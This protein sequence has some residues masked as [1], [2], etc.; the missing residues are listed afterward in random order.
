MPRYRPVDPKVS[1][2]ELDAHVLAF[3]KERHVFRASLERRRGA[4]EWVFYDGPPTANNRPHIGHVEARTFKDLYPRYRTMT[5]HYVHRKAGWD[6][7]GLPVEVEVERRIGT[8]SKRD[9]EEFGVARFVELCRTSVKEYVDDWK[10]MSDRLGHWIDMEDDYW[11]MDPSYVQSVWWALKQ[12]FDR[13]LLFQDHRSAAYCPRCGT[14][15]SDAEVALGYTTVVD[16]SVYVRFPVAEGPEAVRGA[17]LLGWTTTPWTLPSNL[18]LAVAADASYVRVRAG[19]EEVVLAEPLVGVVLPDGQ[20]EVL[21]RLS[22]AEMVGTR[23]APPYDN[24]DSGTHRVVAADFVSM[25]DGTGIVH[26]APGFGEDDLQLGRREGWPVYKPVDDAGHFTD[27][28]PAFVRGRFVKDTDPDIIED[29]RARGLL[30]RHED[31]EHTYP[32]CWRCSTPLLYL[33]RTSWYVR[34]TARKDGLLAANEETGW[35]PDYIKHGRYGNWLANNVDWALSRERYWGTPLPLWVCP[36]GHV[37]AVGS[38][39]ELTALAG[40]DVTGIDP[41][42]PAIDEVAIACPECAAEARRVPEVIDAWFD[43]GAMPYAQWGYMGPDSP[44]AEILSRRYPADFIAEGLDQTR[45]WFYSL[46]AEG[47]LLF[48]RSSY[49][50]VICH[51][52]VVDR[53]GRKM[54]KRL[55]NVIDPIEALDRYGADALRWLFVAGG[56]PWANRRLSLDAIGEVVRQFLLTLWNVYAFYV[57]YANVDEPD[58]AAAAP[59]AERPPL[60]RWILSRLHHLI[61]DVR[62]GMDEFDATGA[63]RRI[64]EF[65]N[66]L[67]NWYVRRSRRRFWDPV[68]AGAGTAATDKLAAHATLEECLRTLSLLL[69][70]FTPFVAEELYGNLVAERDPSAPESVHLCDFPQ[71]DPAIFDD[72]LEQEMEE[73]RLAVS[74]G[75]TVRTEQKVRVRQPLPAALLHGPVDPERLAPLLPLMAE[76][77]NVK[78]VRFAASADELGGWRARPNFRVMGPRLGTRAPEAAA[79]LA[80]DDGTL[81]AE[82]AHGR[83]VTV[84][85]PSG[86]AEVG[87]EDVSLA[88]HI[89]AGW[90]LASGGAVTVALDLELTDELRREGLAREL[91]HHVQGLRKASGLEVADR[92]VLGIEAGGEPAAAAAAY[93]DEIAAEVLATDVRAAAVEM[94]AGSVDV[95]LEGTPVRLT[96]RRA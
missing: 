19:G 64:E 93:R 21:A 58:L 13:G 72:A 32:L 41:H 36:G 78:E 63:A 14:G 59:L 53:D 1:F 83:P 33:A 15:L 24:V 90:A 81:A 48:G 76:E 87:P 68:R 86:A 94:A 38:L 51:G 12:L 60:D 27:E 79:A 3:W 11:T 40:R 34:T 55:G 42:R 37:T 70:P 82:L 10:I 20:P 16:P 73:V 28:A 18:G 52:L 2:P 77:L 49:R 67:S 69:A 95:D 92:I 6:C 8:K 39:A 75:R 29:L 9:I 26:V 46:M 80:A 61:D 43:S 50:N 74:L 31:Y 47:V 89:R 4:P 35:H 88:Q 56:S 22:G 17:A 44:A 57:T 85:L 62:A 91:I 30:L 84:A 54:S 25:E 65:V 23:Y 66:D 71:A 45:G 5:G 96:L 7:H